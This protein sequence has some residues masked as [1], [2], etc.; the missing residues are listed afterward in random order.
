[1]GFSRQE[2]WNVLL[3]SASRGSSQPRNWIL[4]SCIC[5]QIPYCW[6]TGEASYIHHSGWLSFVRGR[7]PSLTC[8]SLPMYQKDMQQSKRVLTRPWDKADILTAH[9]KPL[10]LPKEPA[11]P[12]LMVG[13]QWRVPSPSKEQPDTAAGREVGQHLSCLA[14]RAGWPWSVYSTEPHEK[15]LSINL[16]LIIALFE[17]IF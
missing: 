12:I 11:L 15:D 1:M 14:P 5:R 8:S 2:Y 7:K 16:F 10:R 17:L 13:Q 3:V 9:Y 6:A 4:V